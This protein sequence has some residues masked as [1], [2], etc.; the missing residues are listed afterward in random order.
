V[1]VVV[2]GSSERDDPQRPTPNLPAYAAT[3]DKALF[4]MIAPAGDAL[5]P[6][7]REGPRSCGTLPFLPCCSSR[8]Y[9]DS[10]VSQLRSSD[11]RLASSS[12]SS[13]AIV[14]NEGAKGIP[15]S[16]G[17]GASNAVPVRVVPARAADRLV[18][19][20]RLAAVRR[21]VPAD[22]LAPA[23]LRRLVAVVRFL[24]AV[25]RFLPAVLRRL[26]AVVRFLAAVLRFLPAVL[27]RLVAVVRFFAAVLRFLAVPR[28]LVAVVRFLAAVLRFL[29]AV[30]RRL[31]AVVRFFAA[32]PRFFA[33][34]VR[35]FA[36]VL[37]FL[38]V[39]RDAVLRFAPVERVVRRA[40][41]ERVVVLR[42]VDRRF[43]PP[44]LERLLELVFLRA[45]AICSSW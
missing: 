41:V 32:V 36:A 34:V 12:V 18:V 9:A 37:R 7:K 30:L 3:H 11:G 13:G 31:V 29:P 35:F 16:I 19:L 42:A 25:L 22:R 15:L 38:P 26:V 5:I 20:R 21:F 40:P 14:P 39:E 4:E 1:R 2:A 27:R 43:V 23:V 10:G 8:S 44:L 28:R 17:L 33:A 24:A 6:R 45:L